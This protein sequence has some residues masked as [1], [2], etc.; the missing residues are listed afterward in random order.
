[1]TKQQFLNEGKAIRNRAQA[2]KAAANTKKKSG[3]LSKVKGLFSRK[4][5]RRNKNM[6]KTQH[7]K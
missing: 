4:G 7:C 3:F 5:G 6:R 1:M 2:R